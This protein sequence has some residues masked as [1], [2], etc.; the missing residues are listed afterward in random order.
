MQNS[1]DMWFRYLNER[2]V[3]TEGLRDIGLPEYVIDYIEDA[4]PEAPEKS[5]VLM[6]NLWKN[7][8]EYTSGLK[9]LQFDIVN[10]VLDNIKTS[11]IGG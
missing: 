11:Y 3:I 9:E 1:T 8:R 6:A 5:K 10:T 7:D 4:M 2:T